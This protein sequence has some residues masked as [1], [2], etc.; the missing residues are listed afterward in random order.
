MYLLLVFSLVL[1]QYMI[2]QAQNSAICF[3]TERPAPEI[4]EFA[5]QLAQDGLQYNLDVFI[6]IDDNTFTTSGINTSSNF[7]LLQI[8]NSECIRY[9]YKNAISLREQW[10]EVT[11]W[12][13]LFSI[14]VSFVKTIHLF[15]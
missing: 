13:K 1:Y 12:T 6:M 4:I 15:G 5:R 10:R 9:G 8:P 11:S 7:R 14:L 3:L 2:V